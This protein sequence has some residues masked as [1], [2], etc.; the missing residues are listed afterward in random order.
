MFSWIADETTVSPVLTEGTIVLE[1]IYYRA[2]LVALPTTIRALSDA[3][4]VSFSLDPIAIGLHLAPRISCIETRGSFLRM[5]LHTPSDRF[6]YFKTMRHLRFSLYHVITPA[7]DSTANFYPIQNAFTR[8]V[9]LVSL[10]F[11]LLELGVFRG[12]SAD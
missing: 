6:F 11:S 5:L 8:R 12:L 3:F 9:I 10:R 4:S 2:R 7:N 1:W